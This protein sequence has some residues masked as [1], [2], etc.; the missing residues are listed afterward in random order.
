MFRLFQ[1]DNVNWKFSNWS[2]SFILTTLV[3]L[4]M[5]IYYFSE[6]GLSFR[7]FVNSL[8]LIFLG[9][10]L[11]KNYNESISQI[12]EKKEQLEANFKQLYLLIDSIPDF[13][14]LKNEEGKWLVA[15]QIALQLFQLDGISWVGKT[16]EELAT[17]SSM[18]AKLLI[19]SAQSEN[20]AWEQ[21]QL[22]R[23]EKNFKNIDGTDTYYD[24]V[25]VPVFGTNDQRRGIVVIGRDIT[26]QK[27]M[28]EE[29]QGINLELKAIINSSPLA[30]ISLALDGRVMSWNPTAERLFGWKKEE[31]INHPYPL[32]PEENG[33]KALLEE[34]ILKDKKMIEVEE[35]R[36]KKDGTLIDV[37]I[38]T[39]HLYDHDQHII[40]IIT[41]ISD[42]TKRK[43]ALRNLK[44]IQFALN[45]SAIVS[46]SDHNGR[47]IYTN[48]K[49]CEI[50]EYEKG[51]LI[52]SD[53]SIL[54]SNFHSKE[55]FQDLWKTIE[56]GQVWHGEIRNRAKNGSFFWVDTTIVPI[57][58]QQSGHYQYVS[59]RSNIT[60]KKLVEQKIYQMAYHDPLTDLPNRRLFNKRLVETLDKAKKQKLKFAIM[61]IDLK[62]FKVIN[63]T[64]GHD[65]GDSLLQQVAQRLTTQISVEYLIARVGG[66]EFIL[67]TPLIHRSEAIYHTADEISRVFQNPFWL[68]D[69]EIYITPT[70]GI[71]F[72]PN[73]GTDL[74]ILKKRADLAMYYG[75][76]HF[77][78]K[79][80]VY[81]SDMDIQIMNLQGRNIQD[82][83]I[84]TLE[85]ELRKAIN[86]NELELYYQP[87]I[88]IQTRQL[89]G[90]EALIR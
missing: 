50:S 32:L 62:R 37:S 77:E 81:N 35:M 52:G 44:D 68:Q 56:S 76:K 16:S 30:I 87:Q 22:Y 11:S 45:E 54:N 39:A 47:I 61:V 65:V 34:A 2:Y 8:I 73:H 69:H 21:K 3:L 19:D 60:E 75:K 31:I 27:K 58:D 7:D 43:R 10:S 4:T 74:E 84:P 33:L 40:G 86:E 82:V 53:H 24:I 90:M 79:Y 9:W 1:T 63:D 12:D 66:D 78:Q 57:R 14:I 51:E 55:F 89:V 48:Q 71:S 13:I 80:H 88:N 23:F 67:L 5:I 36:K 20:K 72:Y 42:I 85:N 70:I 17:H 83:D 59:I 46:I 29:L 28:K 15:N 49:N 18:N 38:S 64:F 25:K 26:E 6:G 41:I